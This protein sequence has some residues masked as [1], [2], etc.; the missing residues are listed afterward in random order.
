MQWKLRNTY[1]RL[2]R[3]FCIGVMPEKEAVENYQ[4][5]EALIVSFG[6]SIQ[7]FCSCLIPRGRVALVEFV[8]DENE[9]ANE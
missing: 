2:W 1:Q 3:P 6:V 5:P 7:S 9:S 8:V 4:L